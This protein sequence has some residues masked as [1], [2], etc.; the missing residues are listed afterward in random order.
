MTVAA[1]GVMRKAQ[2]GL[3]AGIALTLTAA[4]HKNAGQL[5]CAD[6]VAQAEGD[7]QRI[8]VNVSVTEGLAKKK[9]LPDVSDRRDSQTK[10][11]VILEVLIG[12][13]GTVRC[14]DP[15]QGDPELLPRSID[16]AK[17]WRFQ[18]Y[19]LNGQPINVD[20]TIEFEFNKGEVTAK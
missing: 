4:C 11:T 2:V 8:H 1:G 18:P 3:L 9:A 13:D 12:K 19:R 17:Q 7:N 20:T 15:V 10:S 16:A 5:R 14:A 6:E